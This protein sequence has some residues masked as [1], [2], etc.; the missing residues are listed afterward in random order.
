MSYNYEALNHISFQKFAQSL[1]VSV[2]PETICL[3]VQ[4]PD[5]GRDAFVY[6]PVLE[7]NKFVVFQIK[8]STKPKEASEREAIDKLIKSEKG[9]VASLIQKGATRYYLVTNV[10]GTAHPDTGSIDKINKRLTE[11]FNIP[12]FIWWRDD[13]DAK[14]DNASDVKWSYPEICRATDV[15][16]VLAE[17]PQHTTKLEAAQTIT[18][19]MGKQYGADREIKFKQ[20]DLKQQITDIF[21]DIPIG[22]KTPIGHKGSSEEGKRI[23]RIASADVMI[24]RYFERLNENMEFETEEGHLFAHQEL[25]ADFLLN[26]P[27]GKGVSKLVL[28]G[29]PGQGKSTVTQFLCQVNRLKI[30]P[31]Y[32]TELDN[33]ATAYKEAPSRAP[34]R[35]DLRDYAAWVAGRHPYA[36][37]GE[38]VPPEEGQ[39]SL[40]S[41]LKMH[42]LWDSGGLNLTQHDLLNFFVRA[43]SV[44]VLDGFDEV[45]DIETRARVV[46]EICAAADR[47]HVHALSLQIIV[48]SRPAAFANSP[49]FPEEDWIH[50]QLNDLK[51]SNITAYKE[52][53]EKSQRLTD[54]EKKLLTGT[55]EDKLRQPHLRDLSRN[56][57]QLAILLRL[58]HVKGAALPDKRTALYDEYMNIF[59]NREVEKKQI[60]ADHRELILSIHGLLAWVLQ[61]Q[62]E[63]GQGSGRITKEALKFEVSTYLKNEEHDPTLTEGLLKDAVERIGTLVSRFQDTFEFEVQPLREYFAAR[64][65]YKTAPYSPPRHAKLGTKPDRFAALASSSYWTNVTRFFCGFYDV[66]ELPSLVDEL[67][68]ISEKDEYRLISQPRRLTLMLLSDYVFTQSPKSI[69]RL[70]VFIAKQPDIERLLSTGFEDDQNAMSL[71]ETAGGKILF[72]TCVQMLKSENN[73]EF[74]KALRQVIAINGDSEKVKKLWFSGEPNVVGTAD[75]LEEV[76]DIGLVNELT[77]EEIALVAGEDMDMHVRLLAETNMYEEILNDPYLYKMAQDKFF[78][79]EMFSPIQQLFR[80]VRSNP[81]LILSGLLSPNLFPYFTMQPEYVYI[82]GFERLDSLRRDFL[83]RDGERASASALDPFEEFAQF[84]VELMD[85]RP[86]IWRSDLSPWEKLVDRGYLEAPNGRLFSVISMLSTAVSSVWEKLEDGHEQASGID[87]AT[88]LVEDAAQAKWDNRGFSSTPGLVRRLFFAKSKGSDQDWWRA[89]LLDTEGD[90]NVILVATLVCWGSGEVISGLRREIS[91][92]LNALADDEWLW[93]WNMTSLT[94]SVARSQTYKLSHEWFMQNEGL[95]ERLA[96]ALTR[97]LSDES[98]RRAVARQCFRE[99]KGGDRQVLQTAAEWELLSEPYDAIDWEFAKHLSIQARSRRVEHLFFPR[100]AMHRV[101]VPGEVAKQVL[102]ECDI[103]NWQFVSLCERSLSSFVAEGAKKVATVSE[104]EEWFEDEAS[105]DGSF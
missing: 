72:E 4:Q 95:S 71:P 23:Q 14:L 15:L 18:G 22:Y 81:L 88:S 50:L 38:V 76:R 9:K 86:E 105:R 94:M 59:M 92:L 103:H 10:Q 75:R 80:T 39:R 54:A 74:C 6:D 102:E 68:E 13:L 24:N 62:V 40:E 101:V 73:P 12:C 78:N 20:A 51:M 32:R 65:L 8:F 84:V 1:I 25:A 77:P 42:I 100:R 44:I 17:R 7:R 49:G 34:F 27:F 64:H 90:G 69:R 97:R 19:Y 98:D 41:F 53:W 29:A 31:S 47:L 96:V 37:D 85:V 79:L 11:Q 58:M 2:Y 55:L 52:K 60:E 28:E 66:G 16:Q 83:K 33:V 35:I 48:T 45:A 56:P 91:D 70:I 46:E 30:L 57:M 67:I 5:G 63:T 43:H 104:E 36:I 93:F 61:I 26:M 82:M 87:L 99:C 3:P 89:R 21:V